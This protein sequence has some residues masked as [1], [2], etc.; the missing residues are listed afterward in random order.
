MRSFIKETGMVRHIDDLGRVVIPIE[1]RRTLSIKQG[2]AIEMY[3]EDNNIKL[4][5]FLPDCAICNSL[6]KL[7]AFKDKLICQ[8]CVD[9]I[10]AVAMGVNSSEG[11]AIR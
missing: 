3:V 2:D 5:K 1:L 9:Q 11:D 7:Q 8:K 6:E 10:V 4:K